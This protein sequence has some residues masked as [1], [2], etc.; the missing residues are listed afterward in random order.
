MS[1]I[2]AKLRRF[3]RNVVNKAES[4]RDLLISEVD[5]SIKKS[6][7]EARETYTKGAKAMYAKEMEEVRKEARMIISEAKNNRQSSVVSKRS[8]IIDSV[9]AELEQKL[10]EYVKSVE[11]EEYF[12]RRL[13]EASDAALSLSSIPRKA[14][15]VF[16][17]YDHENR[18]QLA[19]FAAQ[20]LMGR[21]VRVTFHK[22][23]TDFIGGCIIRLPNLGRVIDNSM[24]SDIMMERERFLSWS[25]LSV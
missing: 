17:P 15:I 13:D 5:A 6:L 23:E 21:G 12:K 22:S 16:A 10:R 8:E 2:D 3:E 1:T 9:F 24:K 20:K 25:N 19:G 11:Y 14:E 18:Q 7:N 4:E